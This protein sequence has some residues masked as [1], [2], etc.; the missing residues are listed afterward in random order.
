MNGSKLSYTLSCGSIDSTMPL[1]SLDFDVSVPSG[2]FDAVAGKHNETET[3]GHYMSQKPFEMPQQPFSSPICSQSSMCELLTDHQLR[4]L[5]GLGTQTQKDTLQHLYTHIPSSNVD[6][7]ELSGGPFT[8]QLCPSA[9]MQHPVEAT[10]K[11]RLHS[12]EDTPVPI[13][14]TLCDAKSESF[15]RQS[16]TTATTKLSGD[17]QESSNE[18]GLTPV[19]SSRHFRTHDDSETSSDSLGFIQSCE[20]LLNFECSDKVQ[21]YSDTVKKSNNMHDVLRENQSTTVG[22]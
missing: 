9:I 4:H 15:K 22:K 16:E 3:L 12:T 8:K 10:Q 17:D 5:M 7:N 1:S 19:L 11:T 6:S 14:Q 13:I 2:F 21:A 18:I 20:G